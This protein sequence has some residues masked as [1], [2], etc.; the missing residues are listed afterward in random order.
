MIAPRTTLFLD[1]QESADG[2]GTLFATTMQR[3]SSV[4][5]VRLAPLASRVASTP[6]GGSR[7][8][9]ILMPTPGEYKL[10]STADLWHNSESTGNASA[11][12][13]R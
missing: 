1:P 7:R 11:V 3:A 2:S 9:S 8:S 12:Q 13:V 5:R 4:A 10:P 6:A